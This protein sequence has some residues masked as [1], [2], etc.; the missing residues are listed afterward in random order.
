MNL[1]ITYDLRQDY[2]DEGFS[3]EET[4]E[5][6]SIVT[7]DAIDGAL[8][9]LGHTTERIGHIR[10]LVKRLASGERWDL[11]FNIAEGMHGF[12]RE[13]AIPAL[14][15]AYGIPCTFSDPLVLAVALHKGMTKRLIRDLGLPTP[16]FCVVS[17]PSDIAAVKLEY[18]LFAK[19]IA[20]GTGKGITGLSVIETP[21]A[22]E[23]VCTELLAKYKQPVIVERFLPGREYTVAVFGTG[24][25]TEAVGGMEVFLKEEAEKNVY[26]YVNKEQCESLVRY[27]PL[28]G[29]TAERAKKLCEAVWKGLGCRDAGRIDL[30]EDEDGNPNFLEINPLAGLH[31]QH[32]DLPI[33]C[34]F[35]GIPY[36]EIIRR[37]MD[38][39]LKRVRIAR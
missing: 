10:N 4:A 7:I 36:L 39:A 1:G 29:A 14:L 33:I 9:R 6:D 19:P 34:A 13:A 21:S 15:E 35:L 5:F 28:S 32:S 11:V 38:S 23:A 31:P 22:L 37:I 30:R 27:E 20:E 24:E 16:D 25:T 26:S 2:L 12:C 8:Q 17:E 3:L 18:P